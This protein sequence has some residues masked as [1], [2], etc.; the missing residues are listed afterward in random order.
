[1][2]WQNTKGK[3]LLLVQ[4]GHLKQKKV[5][6]VFYIGYP[7]HLILKIQVRKIVSGVFLSDTYEYTSGYCLISP[8]RIKTD[9]LL[10]V[11]EQSPSYLPDS[12]KSPDF[13]LLPV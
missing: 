8:L 6:A 12:I 7:N 1:M 13:N 2:L 10:R 5:K 11:G 9:I 4:P 3:R